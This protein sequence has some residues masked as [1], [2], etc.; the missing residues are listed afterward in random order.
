MTTP[1]TTPPPTASEAAGATPRTDAARM[2]DGFYAECT[3]EDKVESL[4][5]TEVEGISWDHYDSSLEIFSKADIVPSPEQHAAILAMGFARYWINF[6]DGTDRYCGGE[7]TQAA[8]NRYEAHLSR[9]VRERT[10]ERDLTTA[11][12]RIELMKDGLIRAENRAQSA[13]S[14]LTAVEAER[15]AEVERLDWLMSQIPNEYPRNRLDIDF[16][17]RKIKGEQ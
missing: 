8:Y 7:R 2:F 10:L 12:Q 17:I 11:R 15:D 6:P 3:I 13:E 1:E 16:A 5:G 14:R 4:F 9:T